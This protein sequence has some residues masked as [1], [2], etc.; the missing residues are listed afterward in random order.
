MYPPYQCLGTGHGVGA[1]AVFRLEIDPELLLLQGFFHGIGYFLF[2]YK[3]LPEGITVEGKVLTVLSFDR[4]GGQKGPVSDLLGADG[5]VRY[6][7][8][9]PLHDHV[10]E[11][12]P[13][14][15][16]KNPSVGNFLLPGLEAQ[17]AV[18]TVTAADG[19]RSGRLFKF[20]CRLLQQ[21][22]APCDA[23]G[24][25]VKLE[26]LDIEGDDGVLPI[27]L[28]SF[29]DQPAEVILS[30]E[31]CEPVVHQLVCDRGGI[32]ELYYACYPVKN[33]LRS[34][35]L[36]D[37]IGGTVGE[38]HHLILLTAALCHDYHRDE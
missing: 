37:E 22:I 19:L 17:E 24:I 3:L 6:F 23:V 25:V 8:N 14:T 26:V 38:G 1:E 10:R 27:P 33:Y 28:K 13:V 7:V 35:G 18:R 9:T 36:R 21:F 12:S 31:T 30:V 32:P 15:L 20:P 34:V 11:A 5:P 2:P 29:V 16:L 4:V